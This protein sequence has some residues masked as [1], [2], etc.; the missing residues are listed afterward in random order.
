M[1]HRQGEFTRPVVSTDKKPGR[2]PGRLP[3]SD[4]PGPRGAPVVCAVPQFTRQSGV[5]K[6]Y[7]GHPQEKIEEHPQGVVEG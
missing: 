6:V 2:L 7:R 1:R 5:Y 3:P 4:S